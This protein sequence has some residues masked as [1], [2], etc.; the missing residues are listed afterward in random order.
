MPL[1]KPCWNRVSPSMHHS[2]GR[3]QGCYKSI[4]HLREGFAALAA[5]SGV[6]GG[7]LLASC[8]SRAPQRVWRHQHRSSTDPQRGSCPCWVWNQRRQSPGCVPWSL[9]GM[10]PTSPSSVLL[11]PAPPSRPQHPWLRCPKAAPQSSA[12]AW[13]G[14]ISA[15]ITQ[16]VLEPGTGSSPTKGR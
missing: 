1:A 2:L 6:V 8:G 4:C 12:I 7:L 14:E 16:V 5:G 11:P 13:V 10:Q 3:N 15:G 9:H